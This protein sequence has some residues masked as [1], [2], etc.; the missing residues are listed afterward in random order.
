[1]PN[2][3]KKSP[4]EGG[5]A[6]GNHEEA[7]M[8]TENPSQ[9]RSGRTQTQMQREGMVRGPWNAQEGGPTQKCWTGRGRSKKTPKEGTRGG[10]T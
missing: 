3:K 5:E 9:D 4:R 6:K 2:Q 7:R 1:M 8:N 10:G